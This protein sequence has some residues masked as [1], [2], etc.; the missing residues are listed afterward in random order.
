MGLAR[1]LPQL[2]W[3]QPS[4]DFPILVK[5]RFLA[6]SGSKVAGKVIGGLGSK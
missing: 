5:L 6:S 2:A 3:R 4:E 1:N